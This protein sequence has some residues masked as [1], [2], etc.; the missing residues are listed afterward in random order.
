[1]ARSLRK[2]VPLAWFWRPIGVACALATL[3]VNGQSFNAKVT[4]VKD[5]RTVVVVKDGDM[6]EQVVRLLALGLPSPDNKFFAEARENLAKLV[7]QKNVTVD[8]FPGPVQATG[9]KQIIGR[10]L[11]GSED[12]GV[13]QIAQGFAYHDRSQLEDQ[14][15]CDRTQ[16]AEAEEAAKNHRLGFWGGLSQLV[17]QRVTGGQ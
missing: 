16:Y 3:P 13:L 9:E 4:L 1:M 10:V 5:G 7:L 15:T 8:W 17:P 14:S 11:H 6:H 12:V 2:T